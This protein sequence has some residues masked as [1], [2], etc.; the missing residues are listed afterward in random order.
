[1]DSPKGIIIVNKPLE[2]TSMDVIRYLRRIT[3]IK[4]IGHAGTLDPLASGVLIVAIGKATKKINE[5]MGMVKKYKTTIDLRAFS[6]TD[7]AEG[8]KTQV[9]IK[10]I[11]TLEEIEY[12]IKNNFIG[13]ID[14]T[15][16]IYSAIKIKGQKAYD[17]AR[18]GIDVEIKSRKV[19]I[20]K[21]KI[22][23]YEWPFLTL[24]IKC[25]K[26]TYIR[27]LGKDIGKK[28]HTGG[29]LTKLKRTAIGKYN[30]KNSVP[31]NTLTSYNWKQYLENIP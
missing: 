7:D 5:F 13:E 19:M 28:L 30:I 21:I 6:T 22:K 29:Y 3:H 20:Y 1:M 18:K 23:K 12:V 25:S 24:K 9:K 15:P 14:Q 17:L 11:P 8:E 26:G 10:K 4:K 16:P 27:S 31:L 2:I